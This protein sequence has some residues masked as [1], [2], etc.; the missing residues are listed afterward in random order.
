MNKLI[1]VL[2][3]IVSNQIV[4]GQEF[5]GKITYQNTYKSENPQ[6]SDQL[7][8]NMMG[9]TQIYSIKDG[10]YKSEMNGT[11]M[12]WQLFIN[13]EDKLYSKMTHSE[14][15]LWNDV[16]SNP[17]SVIQVELNKN[18]TEILGYKC[19]ELILTCAS[20]TQKYYFNSSLKVNATL[21]E[22][23]KLGNWYTFLKESNALPLKLI[24]TNAQFTMVSIATE[25]IADK[26]EETDFQL[27]EGM[28]SNKSPF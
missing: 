5:E 21:F 7:W 18:V 8:Q 6:M 13:S 26:F 2:L 24:V 23:H 17:D 25:V 14:I 3:L 1:L 11:M 22:N 20:G 27:P 9:D 16:K 10:N 12:Q 4:R 28:K 15:A 19:D